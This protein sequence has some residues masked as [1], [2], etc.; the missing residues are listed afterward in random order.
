MR[1]EVARARRAGRFIAGELSEWVWPSTTSS[2]GHIRENKESRRPDFAYGDTPR[3]TYGTV[4]YDVVGGDVTGRRLNHAAQGVTESR[5]VNFDAL[6]AGHLR[7]QK[8][9]SSALISLLTNG[10]QLER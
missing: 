4:A 1:F 10:G 5:Y 7:A 2:T 8:E 6:H 3:K 9:I